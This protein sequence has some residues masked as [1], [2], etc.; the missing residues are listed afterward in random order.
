MQY[1][2]LIEAEITIDLFAH[3]Q[4]H[5]EVKRCWRKIEGRWVLIDHPFVED[6]SR[7]D[8][9][10]LVE[11]LQNTLRTGGGVM[12]AFQAGLLKGFASVETKPL[13]SRG[14][15]LQL[16][17]LHV[18]SDCRGAGVGRV[19]FGMAAE[20]ARAL[21]AEKLYISGHSAEETQAFYHAMGCQEAEEYDGALYAAEP[22]DCHLEFIL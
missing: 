9:A 10:F 6:W 4:R 22:C 17:A 8:Y 1:R 3:F 11:C 15:Y 7:E 12:G 20:K 2:H 21:G 18:S 16:S 14:Q 5:Q 13:G 19:L